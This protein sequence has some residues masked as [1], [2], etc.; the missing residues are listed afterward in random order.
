MSYI[1]E[2]A[3]GAMNTGE[4]EY[5]SESKIREA[6]PEPE[7]IKGDPEISAQ[8]YYYERKLGNLKRFQKFYLSIIVALSVLSIGIL[9]GF[10]IVVTVKPQDLD[11]G[12]DLNK[13]YEFPHFSTNDAEIAAALDDNRLYQTFYGVTYAGPNWD[14]DDPTIQHQIALD[15]T[16]L[17]RVT[18]RVRVTSYEN[19]LA[20]RVVQVINDLLNVDLVLNINCGNWKSDSENVRRI[21]N[22][23]PGNRIR[24]VI[25]EEMDST[26]D[27]YAAWDLM[28]KGTG[29]KVE[30][31]SHEQAN[32]LEISVD[33]PKLAARY[34]NSDHS[35]NIYTNLETPSETSEKSAY[36]TS[37]V[38][39]VAP[40]LR[41]HIQWFWPNAFDSS[42][43]NVSNGIFAE[44]RSIKPAGL[45]RCEAYKLP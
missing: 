2:Y 20:D 38:C 16:L 32:P 33:H 17:S 18:P 7:P 35:Q 25:I 45:P 42:P 3:A 44:N 27:A 29:V 8:E 40:R 26:E 41:D 37:W 15:L 11:S 9:I 24:S 34:L 21:I 30:V 14:T 6:S 23:Y 43:A 39:G 13:S 28:R 1:Q 12:Y 22:S 4:A 5:S 31:T 36:M 19:Q 10:V